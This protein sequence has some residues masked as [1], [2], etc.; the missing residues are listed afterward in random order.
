MSLQEFLFGR[1]KRDGAQT[2]MLWTRIRMA[3][4][5]RDIAIAQRDLTNRALYRANNSL[6]RTERAFYDLCQLMEYDLMYHRYTISRLAI[7][8]GDGLKE[9]IAK[10][11]K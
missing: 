1:P 6:H 9:A 11:R 4:H 2:K 5:E 10:A 3:E 7:E 8:D